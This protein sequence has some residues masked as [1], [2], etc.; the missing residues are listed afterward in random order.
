MALYQFSIKC[1]LGLIELINWF[2]FRVVQSKIGSV[3]RVPERLQMP[4]KRAVCTK[5]NN[6]LKNAPWCFLPQCFF[7]TNSEKKVFWG[8]SRI[9][10]HFDKFY[11]HCMLMKYTCLTKLARNQ[12]VYHWVVFTRFKKFGLITGFISLEQ[13]NRQKPYLPTV[14]TDTYRPWSLFTVV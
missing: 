13:W 5:L 9:Q 2:L 11:H 7:F 14:L 8:K 6:T 4:T 3:S 12:N 1:T 10:L